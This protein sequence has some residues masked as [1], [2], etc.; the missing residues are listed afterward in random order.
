MDIGEVDDSQSAMQSHLDSPSGTT[1][2]LV[3]QWATS[4]RIALRERERASTA[5]AS[6]RVKVRVS[7]R[8]PTKARARLSTRVKARAP[9]RT[10]AT[11]TEER[12]ITAARWGTRV[13]SAGSIERTIRTG[14]A[15]GGGYRTGGVSDVLDGGSGGRRYT[16]PSR[17]FLVQ[18][19]EG[20]TS[21]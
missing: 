10:R 19:K 13:P 2:T 18:A 6:T 1:V 4:L 5:K 20:G 16:P 14:R 8:A 11:G 17:G 21:L 12:A 7:T 9:G 15:G 3:G